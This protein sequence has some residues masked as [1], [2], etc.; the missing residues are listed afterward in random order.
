MPSVLNLGRIK[1]VWK[2]A[3]NA[4]TAYVLDDMVSHMGHSYICVQPNTNVAPAV[5]TDNAHW[6]VIAVGQTVLSNR[7]DLMWHNGSNVTRLPA[8]GVGTVLRVGQN[9]TLGWGLLDGKPSATAAR[10]AEHPG[11][12][13]AWSNNGYISPD[14]TAKVWGLAGLGTN[15]DGAQNPVYVPRPLTFLVRPTNPRVRQLVLCGRS[16]YAVMENGWV[17]SWGGNISG[18]LGH[19]DTTNRGFPT[20]IESFVQNNIQIARVITAATRTNLNTASETM[21]TFFLDTLG[22]LYACGNNAVGQLGV[23]DT[24]ARLTPVRVGTFEGIT[25]VVLCFENTF[26]SSYLLQGGSLFVTGFN[27]QGQLGLGDTVNRSAFTVVSGL[28]NVSKVAASCTYNTTALSAFGGFALALRGDGTVWSTGF[29]AS[30]QLGVGDVTNRS[31]FVQISGLTNVADIGC[32]SGHNGYSWA[33]TQAGTLATWGNNSQGALGLGDTV[34]KTSPVI[35]DQWHGDHITA[36]SGQSVPPFN[37]KIKKVVAGGIYGNH[38]LTVLTTDGLLFTAGLARGATAWEGINT[39]YTRFRP[40]LQHGLPEGVI[41]LD[42]VMAGIDNELFSTLLLSDGR[43]M[44]TGH[45][46]NGVLGYNE[47]SV[48]NH[49]QALQLVQA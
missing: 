38:N 32:S 39:N 19:G 16:A 48:S 7:G 3:W 14:G 23:G 33:V 15:G 36:G 10:L 11:N 29:N 25:D 31:S 46:T 17:Y 30:G 24:N 40:W 35:V 21:S 45:N 8:G 1:P 37:G 42:I 12:G 34:N 43:V 22:R 6:N 27:G 44:T 41:V 13:G 5:G 28:S 9:N 47:A 2:G 4:A 49:Q 18:Q 26:A 20:R